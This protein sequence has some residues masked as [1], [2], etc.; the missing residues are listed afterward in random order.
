M[1]EAC[2]D[3]TTLRRRYGTFKFEVMPFGLTNMPETFQRM[4]DTLLKNLDFVRVYI[5]DIV[6]HSKT[7]DDHLENLRETLKLT[8]AHGLKLKLNKSLFMVPEN[9]FLGYI[10]DGDGI[11]TDPEKICKIQ[12][13]IPSVSK[14]ELRPFTGLA[15]YYC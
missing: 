14:R 1:E 5:D 12:E 10:I 4:M 3:K 2:K 11:R 6:I 9:V 15:L 13:V 8:V 7:E